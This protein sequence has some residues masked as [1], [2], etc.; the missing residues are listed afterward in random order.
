MYN[1][2]RKANK[3]KGKCQMGVLQNTTCNQTLDNDI[4]NSMEEHLIK[5]L[6]SGVQNR[7]SKQPTA[8]HHLE[9]QLNDRYIIKVDG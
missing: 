6:F 8:E 1:K 3:L 4:Y 2:I 7:I 5:Q 9:K